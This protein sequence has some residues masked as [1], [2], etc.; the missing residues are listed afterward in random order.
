MCVGDLLCQFCSGC[1]TQQ[2]ILGGYYSEGLNRLRN[3]E[4]FVNKNLK[5]SQAKFRNAAKITP[6]ISKGQICF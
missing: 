4:L 5:F 3:L 6:F 2:F 1:G